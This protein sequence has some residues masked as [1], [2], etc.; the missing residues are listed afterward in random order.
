MDIRRT[1]SLFFILGALFVGLTMAL[2]PF[3][4][5]QTPVQTD[6]EANWMIKIDQTA[7]DSRNFAIDQE[8]T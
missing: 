8:I 7:Y 3:G 6:D 5:S 4:K 2:G 1:I